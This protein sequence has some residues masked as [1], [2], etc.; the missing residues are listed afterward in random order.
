MATEIFRSAQAHH[1]DAAFY[2]KFYCPEVVG[3]V[4]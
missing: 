2:R 3:E 4:M 1:L